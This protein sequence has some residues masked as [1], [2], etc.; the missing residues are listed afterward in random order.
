M[1]TNDATCEN[2]SRTVTAKAAFNRKNTFFISEMELI[3]RK[4]LLSAA[5]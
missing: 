3:L 2:K 4:K 1:T 5:F